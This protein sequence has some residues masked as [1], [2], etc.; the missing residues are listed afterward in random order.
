M[1]FFDFMTRMANG[2]PGFQDDEARNEPQKPKEPTPPAE[3]ESKATIR[4]GD[5]SSF[6]VVYIKNVKTH[7]NGNRIQVYCW[8]V[9]T[10]P[11]EVELDKIRIFDTKRE[12]DTVLR[13][14][15]EREFLVYDGPA[16][17][18]EYHEIELDYKTHKEGDYFKAVHNATFTYSPQDKTYTLSNVHLD[19]PIRDIYG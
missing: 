3:E 6:P 1:G 13:G 11:E 15:G 14:N 19:E 7:L 9:S 8:I 4:K 12:L 16:I 10:W 17:L 18:H 2:E 5:D